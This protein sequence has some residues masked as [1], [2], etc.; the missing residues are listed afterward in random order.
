MAAA[1][2]T[3]TAHTPATEASVVGPKRGSARKL[4]SSR[5][6]ITNAMR[7]LA[8]TTTASGRTA[9]TGEGPSR[10]GSERSISAGSNSR[11]SVTISRSHSSTGVALPVAGSIATPGGRAV[12]ARSA[13]S[14]RAS[15]QRPKPSIT[16]A[17]NTPRPGA[18]KG[19][20]PSTGIGIA[21]WI[22]GVP[23]RADMVKV[24]VPSMIEAG[25]NRSGTAARAKSSR[26]IG[27]R[28]KKATNRLTPP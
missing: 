22:A 1:R 25:I 9:T 13:A 18:A 10:A 14:R 28:T 12:R 26:A 7:K 4:V 16:A 11:A 2:P 3:I 8:T 15:H 5:G 23:G 6:R 27:T 24:E 21:F 19:V 20:V 17:A